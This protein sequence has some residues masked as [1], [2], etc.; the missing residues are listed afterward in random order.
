MH[1]TGANFWPRII[2][3]KL[4]AQVDRVQTSGPGKSGANLWP[5]STGCKLPGQ[6]NRVQ[7][8]GAPCG[9]LSL[10][11]AAECLPL[12]GPH[13]AFGTPPFGPP[14]LG[15][16]SSFLQ[17]LHFLFSFLNPYI[18]FAKC[19][20][21]EKKEVGGTSG[22]HERGL[23]TSGGQRFTRGLATSGWSATICD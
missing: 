2:G 9:H 17:G 6:E 5:K 3:R 20:G 16:P 10:R 1:P 13:P 18:T 8:S 14:L 22:G 21:D 7:T 19:H 4:L 23:S 12:T 11:A 15:P